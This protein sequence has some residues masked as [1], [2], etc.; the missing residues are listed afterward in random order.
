MKEF[1]ESEIEEYGNKMEKISFE[2]KFNSINDFNKILEVNTEKFLKNFESKFNVSDGFTDNYQI[3]KYE[4]LS[5]INE[6]NRELYEGFKF[7]DQFESGFRQLIGEYDK[8]MKSL[9]ES[10]IDNKMN[11]I[12]QFKVTEAE[13]TEFHIKSKDQL[14]RFMFNKHNVSQERGYKLIQPFERKFFDVLDQKKDNYIKAVLNVE[15][16]LNDWNL[17]MIQMNYFDNIDEKNKLIIQS[18][19][20]LFNVLSVDV[21]D[22]SSKLFEKIFPQIKQRNQN[23]KQEF[24]EK[25]ETLLSKAVENY[26]KLMRQSIK[27]RIDLGNYDVNLDGIH[28]DKR[29]YVLEQFL[30]DAKKLDNSIGFLSEFKALLE[31]QVN[32]KKTKFT[33]ALTQVDIHLKNWAKQ[34]NESRYIPETIMRELK[35][36][37]NKSFVSSN[38]EEL[39]SIVKKAMNKISEDFIDAKVISIGIYFGRYDNYMIRFEYPETFDNIMNV[40]PNC[41]AIEQKLFVGSDAISY[42]RNSSKQKYENF[43]IKSI[44]KKSLKYEDRSLLP[45]EMNFDDTLIVA[46][47]D[48][49]VHE[50][51]VE[52]LVAA[53]V[54]DIKR[55]VEREVIAVVNSAVFTVPTHFSIKQKNAMKDVANI[56][57]IDSVEILSEITAAALA[58]ASDTNV[59][60]KLEF[61]SVLFVAISGYK[62]DA[63]VCEITG[64]QIKYLSHFQHELS[65]SQVSLI[66]KSRRTS[67]YY[68]NLK[69]CFDTLIENDSIKSRTKNLKDLKNIVIIGSNLSKEFEYY[70]TQSNQFD[71][72][73]IYNCDPIQVI[74]RGT[75]IYGNPLLRQNFDITEVS[76]Y[77]LSFLVRAKNLFSTPS[78]VL[79]QNNTPLPKNLSF[80]FTLKPD[81]SIFPIKI[82]IFENIGRGYEKVYCFQ[83]ES[84]GEMFFNANKH[85]IKEYSQYINTIVDAHGHLNVNS[86]LI[87]PDKSSTILMNVRRLRTELTGQQISD[88]KLILETIRNNTPPPKKIIEP[89]H[90]E[91]ALG[92][93]S[94]PFTVSNE[95][96][97]SLQK[98]KL[99]LKSLYSDVEERLNK[100]EKM[101]SLLKEAFEKQM[102]ETLAVIQ[103]NESNLNKL[104]AHKDFL[105]KIMLK[106]NIFI[107]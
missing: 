28:D 80:R 96:D 34:L 52:T 76:I 47:I 78:M 60:D 36:T 8:S 48:G 74:V 35:E 70:I 39:D 87:S 81:H 17:A 23:K 103:S 91:A 106:T 10:K 2:K 63:A 42:Y 67:K 72:N 68:D 44:F 25:Y 92:V 69:G 20:Q 11:D 6:T 85:I 49:L 57:G 56:A 32:A 88:Q 26:E 83:V 89:V 27:T 46:R 104:N 33:S 24:R 94:F 101:S 100:C 90:M 97:L 61:K 73:I 71:K 1:K 43:D 65:A 66:E 9:I 58:Y 59:T 54:L 21:K 75:A 14:M 13:L 30:E 53:Q 51:S 18:R 82:D 16:Y 50:L 95:E 86:I 15:N 77:P 105:E 84:L 31:R 98:E 102:S 62:C 22:F 64:N 41:V 99:E 12:F 19:Q 37:L 38:D 40:R 7:R 4:L 107:K 93:T 3:I 79:T 5:R 55:D 45:F 29:K